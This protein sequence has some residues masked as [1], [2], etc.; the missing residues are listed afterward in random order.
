M[1]KSSDIVLRMSPHTRAKHD[2]LRG[3][4]EAWFPI[5]SKW[6]GRIVYFDG[7]AGPG[8]YDDG[9]IGSPII[10]LE[11]ARTHKLQ[12]AAEIVFYF[13]E[14]NVKRVEYLRRLLDQKYHHEKNGTYSR[15][16]SNF[17]VYV[18]EGEFN[19]AMVSILDSLEGSELAPSLV[20]VDPFG[21]LDTDVQ[22]LRRV[23]SFRKCELLITFMVGFLDRFA[24]D[25]M[26]EGSIK[27]SLLLND[28]EL[29]NI[30][31]I[32]EAEKREEEWLK[33]LVRG[34]R[35][36]G[37]DE[38]AEGEVHWLSFK[39]MDRS[40]RAMYYLVYFTRSKKG[41]QVMKEA[42][43]KV[44]K[45]GR[46]VFSDYMFMPGQ[47]S[48]LDYC[49]EEPWVGRASEQV[50]Q[51]FKGKEVSLQEIEDFVLVHTTW[52]F[53]RSILRT[54]EEDGRI[55]V[56]SERSRKYTYPRELRI[57]FV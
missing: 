12:L 49:D 42:M 37:Q 16:P 40:N 6:N 56:M 14:K 43:W 25:K 45:A 30:K 7:F 46:Y 44:G 41:L 34:I 48:I 38:S 10:A 53:R 54:L 33:L 1:L 31:S 29:R 19:D 28:E 3:Y 51:E 27:D 57:K 4:L 47:K 35:S 36:T 18:Q 50:Y 55:Q 26:H 32:S 11:V 21:Y 20:F 13:I 24:Y 9:S 5:L 23:L 39:T 52:I 15:L 2:I 22:V 17:R 8:L